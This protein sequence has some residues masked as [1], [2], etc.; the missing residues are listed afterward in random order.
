MAE[1][2]LGDM[3]RASLDGIKD[4][5]DVN[6]VMGS[7][8]HTPSGATVIPV[9][10]VT[11]GFAGGGVDFATQKSRPYQNNGCGG[12]TGISITPV[13][14]LVIGKNSEI[15]LISLGAKES[16]IDKLLSVIEEAPSI[17]QRIK[18]TLS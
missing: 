11:V 13:A 3:I 5:T 7:A 15:D 14:F 4:I 17:I 8:I 10:K 16:G 9:S 18:N 1:G 6:T 2:T 12:G